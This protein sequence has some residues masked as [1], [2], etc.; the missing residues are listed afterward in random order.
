MKVKFD[1]ETGDRNW[2]TYKSHN[3]E[4]DCD[5][6]VEIA[7]SRAFKCKNVRVYG[8][9]QGYFDV[10]KWDKVNNCSIEKLGRICSV[11]VEE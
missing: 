10:W 2:K 9:S 4:T 1:F 5:D 3:I 11:E 6:E 8:E 7:A